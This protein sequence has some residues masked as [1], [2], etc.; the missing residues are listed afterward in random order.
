MSRRLVRRLPGLGLALGF[1]ALSI[2]LVLAGPVRRSGGVS[3]HDDAATPTVTPTPPATLSVSG[4]GSVILTPDTASFVVGVTTNE[5]TLAE[6]QAEATTQMEAIIAAVKAAGIEDRDIQ[7]VNYSVNLIYDYDDDGYATRVIG[8]EVSNQVSVTVRDL[9]ALGALLDAVVAAG[10]NSVYGI[11]FFVED[12][13]AAASQARTM[14]VEDAMRKAEELATAAGLEVARVTY[15]TESYS[16]PPTPYYAPS[17]GVADEAARASV[18]VQAGSS[19]VAV[20]VQMSFELREP[21]AP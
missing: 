3:A 10:A 12:T 21:P 8:Y 11:S 7:T 16:P 13:S 17:A 4:H 2:A 1:A 15:I 5:D 18:P 19:E 20:D 14:A 9:D 6:A